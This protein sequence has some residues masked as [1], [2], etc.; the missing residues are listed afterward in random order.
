MAKNYYGIVKNDHLKT[1]T[2]P[3]QMGASEVF[4]AAG[5]RFVVKNGDDFDAAATGANEL[6]GAIEFIG[7]T[8][9]SDAQSKYPV[10]TNCNVWYE[11]PATNDGANRETLTQ[12]NIELYRFDTADI[13]VL[14]NVQYVLTSAPSDNVFIIMGGDVVENTLFVRMNP[15]EFGQTAVT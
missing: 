13:T 1:F 7:T 10:Q 2:E 14:S 12:A 4:T 5:G 9:S 3:V 8:G 11:M 6:A 15:N